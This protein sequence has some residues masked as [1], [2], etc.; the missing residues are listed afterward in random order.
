MFSPLYNFVVFTLGSGFMTNTN[1]VKDVSY[2]AGPLFI[3]SQVFIFGDR[4]IGVNLAVCVA[5]GIL[6]IL[7]QYLSQTLFGQSC[8]GVLYS[9]NFFIGIFVSSLQSVVLSRGRL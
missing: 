5:S 1:L 9:Y 4:R 7:S 6:S 8:R 3:T 2:T